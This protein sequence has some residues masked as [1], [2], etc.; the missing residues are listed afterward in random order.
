MAARAG[1]SDLIAQVRTLTNAGTAEAVVAGVTYWSDDQ[2]QALLDRT[3]QDRTAVPLPYEIDTEG[4]TAVYKRYFIPAQY[5][6]RAATGAE[7][8]SVVDAAGSAAG[9]AGYT[10]NYDAQ[11]ITFSAS[12]SGTAW[13][14]NY[15]EFNPYRVA[16]EVMET[17]AGHIAGR[18]DVKTDNHDL[19]RSQIWAQY[20]GM[21]RHFRTLAASGSSG[22]GKAKLSRV[23]RVDAY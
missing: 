19:K 7:A 8:F 5:V 3:R 13:Y 18:F 12:Q 11:T 16:A 21:A 2:I 9:T 20:M 1:M 10:V 4:G 23:R 17:K 15:R 14:L 6:E 22:D